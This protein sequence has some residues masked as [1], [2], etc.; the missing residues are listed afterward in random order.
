MQIIGIADAHRSVSEV[1]SL[2]LFPR[3]LARLTTTCA[4]VAYQHIQQEVER[5]YQSALQ[6]LR[7]QQPNLVVCLGD[8]VGGWQEQGIAHP[9]AYQLASRTDAELRACGPIRYC[10]GNHETG[11]RHPGSLA[12]SGLRVDSL[13][14]CVE[15]FG[16]PYWHIVTEQLHLIG[17]CSPLAEYEGSEPILRRNQEQQHR[18]VGDVLAACRQPWVLCT[19]NPRAV[20]PL[21]PLLRPHLS[22]LCAVIFGDYH[23]PRT[24]RRLHHW[25]RMQPSSWCTTAGRV[26]RSC[27]ARGICCP[28]IAPLWWHGYQIMHLEARAFP[29]PSL[30]ATC[31]V[32]PRPPD[33]QALPVSSFWPALWWMLHPRSAF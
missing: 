1:E 21:A 4:A 27:L 8:L 9:S 10:L 13:L 31:V 33:A 20:K 24:A 5:A 14:A 30:A 18:F 29:R 22:R 23:N 17:I 32:L 12:V 11:Y 25:Q 3:R 19:H 2:S 28:G 16:T 26:F 7:Q 15:V 6:Y